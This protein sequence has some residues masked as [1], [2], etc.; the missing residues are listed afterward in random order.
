MH[1]T[2]KVYEHACLLSFSQ[3]ADH[4]ACLRAEFMPKAADRFASLPDN[5]TM[6]MMLREVGKE[7]GYTEERWR[8]HLE[9]IAKKEIDTVGDLRALSPERIEALDLPPVVTEY[10]LRV[11]AGGDQ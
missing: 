11:K 8:Q 1:P 4:V 2:S 6:E 7:R 3:L 5:A 9:R 10:L